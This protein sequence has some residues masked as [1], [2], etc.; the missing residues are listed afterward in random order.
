MP[1][2][3]GT[4]RLD[5]LAQGGTGAVVS[6]EID[7][8]DVFAVRID[9][10]PVADAA[11]TRRDAAAVVKL[12]ALEEGRRLHREQLIDRLWPELSIE[13]A[14][15]R[16]HKAAHYARR[17][18]DRRDAV[19]LRDEMVSLLP[20]AL[21]EIDAV[22]FE[23]DARAALDAGGTIPAERVL[24]RYG[25]TLLP[26]DPYVEWVADRRARL[27]ELREELL[28]QARRWR[29][30]I[31]K[32]PLDEQAHVG[33][34]REL[35]QAGDSH[36]ALRQFER[37]DRRLRR[38]LGVAPG[39]EASE[40]RQ[41]ILRRLDDAGAVSPAELAR[42]EQEIRFC[43]TADG[44]TLAY[45]SSGEGPPLVKAANWLTHVDHDWHSAVWR[46]WLTEL[47]RRHRLIRY[48]VRG[49]GLSDWNIPPATFDDFVSDLETVVDQAGLDRF[50]LLGIS[51][52]AAVAVM[53]AA[54]H[55]DRVSRLVL[56][57]GYAQGT[58]ARARTEDQRRKHQL[59]LDLMHLG[60]GKDEPTF[61]Q[62]FTVQFMPD[63]SRELWDAFNDLQL[64]TSSPENAAR[65]LEVNGQVDIVDTAP[66]VRA[67]TL[68]LHARDDRRPPLEQ[69]RLLAALIP[70]SR[71]VVLESSNHILLADEPAWSVFLAEVEDFLSR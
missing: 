38:E 11:W 17:A 43:R 49:G 34:M 6:V 13:D 47:S 54:R 61:R 66:H 2:G 12:L 18:L 39:P 33:L 5:L 59:E 24:D 65:V 32:N 20:D 41:Q 56:Y 15:P 27:D 36:A 19:V 28:R 16:L 22:A 69:G 70:D 68:V 10:M 3:P 52:G 29:V 23:R 1:A 46:H 57:G 53:Y 58:A 37:M 48:D 8:L 60:W 35:A 62:F 42:L 63:G 14:G 4:A 31:D 30:V 67:P 45:A 55:P 64:R 44:V 21:V 9:G 7:L 40:L 25:A 71:F 51:Q 26:N 50:P